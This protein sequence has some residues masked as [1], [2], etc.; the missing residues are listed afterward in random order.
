M[1]ASTSFNQS[2]DAKMELKRKGS[3]SSRDHL[4]RKL[5]DSEFKLPRKASKKMPDLFDELIYGNEAYPS[6]DYHM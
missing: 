4:M 1:Q 3:S 2:D 5:S 6:I